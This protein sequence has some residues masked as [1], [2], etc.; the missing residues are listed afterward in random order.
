MGNQG[1]SITLKKMILRF[2]RA[3][4]SLKVGGLCMTSDCGCGGDG[5]GGEFCGVCRSTFG[6]REGMKVWRDGWM[7]GGRESVNFHR[8]KETRKSEYLHILIILRVI[9]DG[10]NTK[11][12]K[13]IDDS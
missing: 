11:T 12:N 8:K 1:K 13:N 5:D 9:E 4:N 3:C 2:V 7:D 6:D 10:K